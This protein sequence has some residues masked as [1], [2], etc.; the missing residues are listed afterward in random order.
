MLRIRFAACLA[1]A[2]LCAATAAVAV[3]SGT[4]PAPASPGSKAVN[5]DLVQSALQAEARADLARRRE[6]LGAALEADPNNPAAHWQSGQVL[7]QG[8][9]VSIDEAA[10]E[11]SR[12]KALADYREM[13][14]R[15][16]DSA[17]AQRVLARWCQKNEL[18]DSARAH[19]TRLHELEPDDAEA[20][21]MLGLSW[22][23]G[24]LL[25]AEQVAQRKQHDEK[26]K[27]ALRHWEP[28]ILDIRRQI[29]S[30]DEKQNAAGWKA[31]RAIQDPS[32]IEA[33][34]KVFS[35]HRHDGSLEVV[36]VVG[37]MN[38]PAATDSLL[39]QA[40]LSKWEDVR[41]AACEQL[42]L[43]SPVGYVPK[44]I[45]ALTRP[46]EAR[47]EVVRENDQIRFREIVER[48][49]TATKQEQVLETRVPL[50]IPNLNLASIVDTAAVEAFQH[51]QQTASNVKGS[52]PAERHR[53]EMNK[54][55]YWVLEK[56]TGQTLAQD[57]DAWN[58]WWR[59]QN[60]MPINPKKTQTY[61]AAQYVDV[62]Y[63][64]YVPRISR[65]IGCPSVLCY[66][67]R[68]GSRRSCDGCFA[69]GTKVW[70]LTGPMAIENLEV[71]DEVLSQD[72][73]TGELTYKPVLR[74]TVGRQDLMSIDLGGEKI[75]ATF[76]HVFWV[77]GKGW[78]M[79]ADLKPGDR[80]HS[81]DGWAEIVDVKDL[82]AAD[83][84]NL[85]V[86]DYG[87][88][89]VGDNRLLVHDVT[90]LQP[91]A[92]TVPGDKSSEELASQ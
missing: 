58:V 57:P 24:L 76:G 61:T 30:K 86:A 31:L 92:G 80:L 78:R 83:T 42:H 67:C 72:S 60:Y 32:A 51:A 63:V 23:Q 79:A 62:P 36:K 45:N 29:D 9:W 3:E 82:P 39:R 75:V 34:E 65:F 28:L 49:D 44:L 52:K 56:T 84:R 8:K 25:T 54:E 90:M 5:D 21:K 2:S 48:Q 41:L 18:N 20:L 91:Y 15:F 37:R 27:E 19:A 43:Q 17:E 16:G 1:A 88:Y 40:L 22:H 89:F 33:L 47:F 70:T 50:F 59:Q 14:L 35:K 55:I 81:V 11:A 53:Q 68:V 87:T 38:T 71:G 85:I 12:D 74:R 73:F 13:R 69:L 64:P 77:S 66:P 6:L 10:A 46:A 7:Y 26:A 4:S